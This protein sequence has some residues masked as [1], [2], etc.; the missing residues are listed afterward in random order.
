MGSCGLA[1]VRAAQWVGEDRNYRIAQGCPPVETTSGAGK[2][3]PSGH[4]QQQ[5]QKAPPMLLPRGLND[6]HQPDP[7]LWVKSLPLLFDSYQ[8]QKRDCH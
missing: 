3:L 1:A 7:R 8:A 6:Q 2:E 5:Q 4:Q